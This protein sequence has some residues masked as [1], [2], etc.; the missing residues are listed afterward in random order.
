MA[1]SK[2]NPSAAPQDA[3]DA[4]HRVYG[5]FSL[6]DAGSLAADL[7]ILSDLD[8]SARARI[9]RDAARYGATECVRLLLSIADPTLVDAS[10]AGHLRATPLMAAAVAGHTRCVE[11]LL[12]LSDPA[13]RDLYGETALTLAFF[14][15]AP[16]EC[17]RMLL[18]VGDPA[19]T[20]RN[21]M[22]LLMLAA[23]DSHLDS[24]DL[25]APISDFSARDND[26]DTALAIA[27]S[28]ENVDVALRLLPRS[29]PNA[30][31]NN[32]Q[33]AFD[34]A[35]LR[36]AWALVDAM[37]PRV[38]RARADEALLL[39]G[40]KNM[41]QWTAWLER[42]SLASAIE[43]GLPAENPPEPHPALHRRI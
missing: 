25:L 31:C 21:G 37:A 24:I 32:G 20:D 41:P 10:E 12:P 29:D 14:M 36:G 23:C 17:Q 1:A 42:E 38:P 11:L 13:A 28:R 4:I 19:D 26:G 3:E 15:G 39:A 30:I 34:L 16:I 5:A 22:T 35:V 27:I 33:S 43:P 7:P 18:A 40:P 9:L 8:E 6:D 2:P